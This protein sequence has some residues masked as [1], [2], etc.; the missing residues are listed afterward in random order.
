[1]LSS[2]SSPADQ[3]LGTSFNTCSNSLCDSPESPE[4][5]QEAEFLREDCVVS[6]SASSS[7]G[8]KYLAKKTLDFE[9]QTGSQYEPTLTF[10]VG[11]PLLEFI[12]VV[13]PSQCIRG[14]LN[15]F[16]ICLVRRIL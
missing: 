1:M 6:D 3:D 7:K 10:F 12:S 4:F 16:N 15:K 5:L 13:S 9:G 2:Q 14:Y 11:T 8:S